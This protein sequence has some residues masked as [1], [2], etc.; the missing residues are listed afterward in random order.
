MRA[1][2]LLVRGPRSAPSADARPPSRSGPAHFHRVSAPDWRVSDISR[3]CPGALEGETT[4][5]GHVTA[6]ARLQSGT[7]GFSWHAR[8]FPASCVFWGRLPSCPAGAWHV[9]HLVVRSD[10]LAAGTTPGAF[11][12]PPCSLVRGRRAWQG[13]GG[14]WGSAGGGGRCRGYRAACVSAELV[15]GEPEGGSGGR[16]TPRGLQAPSVL[17]MWG[18]GTPR[19]PLCVCQGA[20]VTC[21]FSLLRDSA[22]P[23]CTCRSPQLR[24]APHLRQSRT[25]DPTR[26]RRHGWWEVLRETAGSRPRPP[27]SSQIQCPAPGPGNPRVQRRAGAR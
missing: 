18:L 11:C 26:S 16:G 7:P 5:P 24:H 25:P 10:L 17:G 21:Q 9:V 14:G 12:L 27:G 20:A 4:Y 15:A 8:A 23:I 3:H 22:A 1:R 6:G 13:A 2:G 19:C